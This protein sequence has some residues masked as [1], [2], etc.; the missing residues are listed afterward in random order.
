M[1]IGVLT[2]PFNNNYGGLLQSYALQSYLKQRGH[3]VLLMKRIP[4]KQGLIRKIKNFI[5]KILLIEPSVIDFNMKN[6]ERQYMQETG[7]IDRPNK[8]KLLDKYNFDTYVVGSDQ[9][10]RFKF[11][12]ERKK[13]YFFD[14]VANKN[15]NKIAFA[16]S[17][18]IDTWEADEHTTKE[19]SELIQKFSAV[20]VREKTGIDLCKNYLKY[21]KAIHLLDPTLLHSAD[22]YRQLYSGAE[23]GKSGKIGVYFLDKDEQKENM[24]VDFEKKTEKSSF[25][26]GRYQRGKICHCYPT[27]Q[28]WLKCFDT[29]DYIITD[30]FHGMIFSIIFRKPFCIVGNTKRGL[31]RFTSL[32]EAF[33]LQDRLIMN[34][35]SLESLSYDTLMSEIDYSFLNRIIAINMENTDKFLSRVGL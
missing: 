18:G 5:K 4:N 16:A 17:F 19:I 12:Q 3:E 25:I 11:I 24:V 30:S 32:L 20:S 33:N 15:A 9:V 34:I 35:S 7:I 6:F 29:A 13:E 2:L 23:V 10:W 27:I 14:F 22:F 1:R 26:I 8:Y 28:Q 21:E 31:A